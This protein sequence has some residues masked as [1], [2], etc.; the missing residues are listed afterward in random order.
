VYVVNN[1]V[2]P[3]GYSGWHTHPGPS[4]V[5]VKFGNGNGPMTATNPTCTPRQAPGRTGFIDAGGGQTCT[6]CATTRA[7]GRW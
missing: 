6:W 1:T 2:A 5:L 7:R 4:V 3:A